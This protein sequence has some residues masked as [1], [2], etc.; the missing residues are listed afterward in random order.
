MNAYHGDVA[1]LL[2]HA[3]EM[4]LLERVADWDLQQIRCMATS[5][6]ASANPLRCADRLSALSGIEYAAQA[7]AAHGALITGADAMRAMTGLLAGVRAVTLFVDRL[8]DAMD[9]ITIGAQ[10]MLVDG[11]RA[12]YAFVIEDERR[13]LLEGRATVVTM[14]PGPAA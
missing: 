10:K 3:G 13:R 14:A 9:V 4:V 5:H 8:D 11:N 12:I 6:R 1:D 2:P 7:I